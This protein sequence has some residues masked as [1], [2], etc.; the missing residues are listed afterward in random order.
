M[1]S[2]RAGQ[3]MRWI[4]GRCV[5][6]ATKEEQGCHDGLCPTDCGR[7]AGWDGLM[8]ATQRKARLGGA[9]AALALFLLAGAANA[10]SPPAAQ[11][12]I[13]IK[14]GH[15]VDGT[16]GPWFQA[17]VAITGDKIV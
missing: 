11:V 13:L 10:Q 7:Q 5:G 12:D 9:A 17:D 8:M 1:A 14:N 3:P 4:Q 16:G 6:S 2:A 15:V